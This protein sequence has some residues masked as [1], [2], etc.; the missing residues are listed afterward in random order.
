M[1]HKFYRIIRMHSLNAY[2]LEGCYVISS[3]VYDIPDWNDLHALELYKQQTYK[4]VPPL[5]GIE[6]LY[7]FG[8]IL[9]R[10]TYGTVYH[11]KR[12]RSAKSHNI[13]I[14]QHETTSLHEAILH[15]IVHNTFTNLGLGFAIPELYEV[16]SKSEHAPVLC[17]AMEWVPG[18]TL[19][20]YFHIYFTKIT[21][22]A[23]QTILPDS[24]QKARA[25]NDALLLDVLVQVAIY[26]TILQ[27]KLQFHHRDLK[28]NN[29]LIRHTSARSRSILRRLDH[30]LLTKPWECHHDVV[31]IDFGFSCMMGSDPFEAG[32]FFKAYPSTINHGRDLALLIYSIH[33]FFPLDQYISPKFYTFLDSCMKIPMGTTTVQLFNG[34]Q[35]DGTPCV[36]ELSVP[37]DEGI[38]HFLQKDSIDLSSCDPSTFLKNVNTILY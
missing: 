2:G 33:A 34:I 20:D 22:A 28:V 30:P 8:P 27:K 35:T 4:I 17:M 10:G 14:K 26:L 16:T 25:K 15:A 18:S 3:N 5:H 24:L 32:T 31:V 6:I 19:L 9:A 36:S 1:H 7:E 37:F 11:A 12:T 29:I 38:Y 23:T 13:V 21:N